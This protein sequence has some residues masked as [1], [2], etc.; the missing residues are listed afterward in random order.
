M[1][2]EMRYVQK[3]E[4]PQ[5]FETCKADL[6]EDSTWDDFGQGELGECK[7]NL[8][9][10]L[11]Q[12]QDQLCI[13]CERKLVSTG[14]H[15]EHI[16]PKDPVGGFPELTFEYT[17]LVVSCNGDQC[18]PPE[19]RNIFKPEDVASCGHKKNNDLDVSEFLNPTTERGIREYFAYGKD[20]GEIKAIDGNEKAKYTINLLNLDNPRLNMARLNA[21]QAI[22]DVLANSNN[23]EFY[24]LGRQ[25]MVEIL[26]GRN[27]PF[28]FVS[29]LKFYFYKPGESSQ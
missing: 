7:K 16:Y 3:G 12:E 25:R 23:A 6:P 20:T 9:E 14:Q 15:I 18:E 1:R 5:F 29:F 13:Y 27:E 8:R 28:P 17:N 26:L 22:F 10:H 2:P 21:P 4:S 24:R 11:I 19:F